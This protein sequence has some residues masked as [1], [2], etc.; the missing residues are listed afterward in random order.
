MIAMATVL[1]SQLGIIPADLIATTQEFVDELGKVLKEEFIK[2]QSRWTDLS[3]GVQKTGNVFFASPFSQPSEF[4]FAI[5]YLIQE[6]TMVLNLGNFDLIVTNLAKEVLLKSSQTHLQLKAL[7]V[8]ITTSRKRTSSVPRNLIQDLI[9]DPETSEDT[10][11][12]IQLQY[13]IM[14][15]RGDIWG[16]YTL[17]FK[18]KFDF[19]RQLAGFDPGP[20]SPQVFL[21]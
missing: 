4:T 5:L 11:S 8:L 1:G 14:P 16:F 17:T 13:R 9:S 21:F 6:L 20:D 18:R 3:H 10:R 19:S 2:V 7:D 15:D 12:R